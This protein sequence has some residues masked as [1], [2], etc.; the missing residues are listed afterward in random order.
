MRKSA[1]E[2]AFGYIA[3]LN[4]VPQWETEHRFHPD[5][6]WRFDFA[7]PEFKVALECEGG[8]YTHGRHT[9]GTGFTKDC[10]KYSTAAAMGWRVLRFT[11]EQIHREPKLWVR[12]LME[13][14]EV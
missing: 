2:Q 10:E 11:G 14:L 3:K 9:R 5:R 4:G 12:L 13:A 6:K 7:W 8:V 1:I